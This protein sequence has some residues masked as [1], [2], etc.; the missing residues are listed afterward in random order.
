MLS[1]DLNWR[2]AQRFRETCTTLPVVQAVRFLQ[3]EV[4]EVAD[5]ASAENDALREL[6]APLLGAAHTFLPNHRNFSG[7]CDSRNI[8]GEKGGIRET[9]FSYMHLMRYALFP[10][11]GRGLHSDGGQSK[12]RPRLQELCEEY[13]DVLCGLPCLARSCGP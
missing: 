13:V 11:P 5:S 8:Q 6:I 9:Q 1:L 3:T 2:P 7:S 10:L 12:L 4:A